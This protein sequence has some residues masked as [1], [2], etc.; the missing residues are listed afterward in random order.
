M[1]SRSGA[2]HGPCGYGVNIHITE[3]T[4]SKSDVDIECRQPIPT[5][6]SAARRFAASL[7]QHRNDLIIV[8]NI[9]EELSNQISR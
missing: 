2:R 3:I 9:L 1:V 5:I 7:S 6:I 4:S 8:V